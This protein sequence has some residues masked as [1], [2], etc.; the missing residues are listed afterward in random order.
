MDAA[1]TVAVTGAGAPDIVSTLVALRAEG[2][3]VVALDANLLAVGFHHSDEQAL[4]PRGD[5]PDF[6]A[7]IADVCRRFRCDG[8]VITVDEELRRVGELRE[9]LAQERVHLLCSEATVLQLCLDKWRLHEWLMAHD[10]RTPETFLPGTV[11]TG[12]L[13][14]VVKPRCGRGSRG[15]FCAETE[16]ELSFFSRYVAD[17]IVQRRVVGED[18]T[19]DVFAQRGE[20]WGVMSRLRIEARGTSIKGATRRWPEGEAATE[21]LARMLGLHGPA[22]IQAI[23]EADGRACIYEVNPRLAGA[24]VLSVRAGLDIPAWI[25]RVLRGLGPPSTVLLRH[26]LVMLRYWAE[27]FTCLG[28]R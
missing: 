28:Q 8:L 22:C 17:A 27:T 10:L 15:V 21:R 23:K 18:Y 13:P 25:C 7:A 20:P 9:Q 12:L 16:E 3:R 26:D 24:S 5:D 14:A 1:I 4:I 6:P 2:A 11:P 19:I